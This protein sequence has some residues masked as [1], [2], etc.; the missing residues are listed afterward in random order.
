ML[1]IVYL[2]N[3]VCAQHCSLCRTYR[4]VLNSIICAERHSF[5]STD[6]ICPE[7]CSFSLL[8]LRHL[9]LRLVEAREA[10]LYGVGHPI[11]QVWGAVPCYKFKVLRRRMCGNWDFVTT[12]R[13]WFWFG[14]C[15]M[16]DY[17]ASWVPTQHKTLTW[18]ARFKYVC[19][20]VLVMVRHVDWFALYP[21]DNIRVLGKLITTFPVGV[22]AE[23]E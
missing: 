8:F 12:C 18:Y 3:I 14:M 13:V 22:L 19:L 20:H 11:T 10:Q 5:F 23:A 17:D 4:C 9:M 16:N 1:N 21:M 2:N 15:V 6:E 7:F